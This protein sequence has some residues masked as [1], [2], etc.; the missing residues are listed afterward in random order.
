[1]TDA[2]DRLET[3]RTISEAVFIMTESISLLLFPF[4]V[5]LLLGM[6]FASAQCVRSAL[7]P[8]GTSVS[9]DLRVRARRVRGDHLLCGSTLLLGLVVSGGS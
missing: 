9:C 5:T 7:T 2:S 8:C 6:I 3:A 4:M 1:M